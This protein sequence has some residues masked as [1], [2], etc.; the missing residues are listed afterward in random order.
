MANSAAQKGKGMFMGAYTVRFKSESVMRDRVKKLN[1]V[2]FKPKYGVDKI[3][4]YLIV[5]NL[6]RENLNK[7][8]T[9]LRHSDE[10]AAEC[11]NPEA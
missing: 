11:Y 8:K 4:P 7:V 6:N 9:T 3:S 2:G 5:L 10:K 1:D